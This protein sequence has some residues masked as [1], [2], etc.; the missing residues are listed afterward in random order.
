MSVNEK[1]LLRVDENCALAMQ[2]DRRRGVVWVGGYG[3]W[4]DVMRKVL[5]IYFCLE[6]IRPPVWVQKNKCRFIFRCGD[7]NWYT[8]IERME[9]DGLIIE[10]VKQFGRLTK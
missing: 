8:A 1:R 3:R 4:V 2:L 6:R 7:E 5:T 10:N 9:R